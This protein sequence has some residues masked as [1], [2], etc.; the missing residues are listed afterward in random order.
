M[1]SRLV[2]TENHAQ[3][4]AEGTCHAFTG[5]GTGR[6]SGDQEGEADEKHLT[7]GFLV[8]LSREIQCLPHGGWENS[9]PE[10]RTLT[11]LNMH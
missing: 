5:V 8:P 6:V 1:G 7:R 3:I 11:A 10:H 4:R 2:G 9:E